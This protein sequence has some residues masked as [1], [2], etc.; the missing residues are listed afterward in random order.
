MLLL[1][2]LLIQQLLVYECARHSIH[3]SNMSVRVGVSLNLSFLR[4]LISS[5]PA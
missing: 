1:V 2:L 4:D 3:A 5:S